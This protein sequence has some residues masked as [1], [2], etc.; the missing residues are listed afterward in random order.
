MKIGFVGVGTMGGPVARNLLPAGQ[1]V[2]VFDL[3]SEAVEV[4][5]AAGDRGQAAT[6]LADLGGCELI[7][8]CLPL[9]QDVREGKG[10][11]PTS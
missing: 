2:C 10:Q 8:T 6:S 9:P 1:S 4:T 7:F 11:T 3:N 5:L